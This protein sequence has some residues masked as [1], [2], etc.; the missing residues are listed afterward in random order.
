MVKISEFFIGDAGSVG[1]LEDIG[2]HTDELGDFS[3]CFSRVF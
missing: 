1:F 2:I 3:L